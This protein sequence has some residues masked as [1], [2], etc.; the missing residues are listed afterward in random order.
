MKSGKKMSERDSLSEYKKESDNRLLK[1][2]A[3]KI[4]TYCGVRG[5]K[6]ESRKKTISFSSYPI[7]NFY[8]G[9]L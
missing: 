4:A 3:V 7:D 5:R 1:G 6:N 8:L 2:M 9:Y